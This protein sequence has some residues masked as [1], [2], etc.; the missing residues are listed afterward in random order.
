MKIVI[1]ML[2]DRSYKV[3][4]ECGYPVLAET[5]D[6]ALAKTRETF[7]GYIRIVDSGIPIE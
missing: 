6:E 3:D 5:L 1:E 2:E 7:F 4:P